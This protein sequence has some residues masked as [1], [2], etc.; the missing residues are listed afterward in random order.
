MADEFA[1]RPIGRVESSRAEP[2]DDDWGAISGTIVLDPAV[3]GVDAVDGLSEFSHL[4][5]VFVFDRVA[6]AGVETGAR[7]PRGNQAWPRVGILAQRAKNR[8]NRVGVSRCELTGVEGLR[9]LVRGLDAIDGTPVLDVKPYLEEFGPRGRVR[10]P[11]WSRE[12]MRGYW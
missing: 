8:P 5:V 1:M 12:L 2:I 10:Q 9:L 11:A 4:E 3:V 6:E 7:H